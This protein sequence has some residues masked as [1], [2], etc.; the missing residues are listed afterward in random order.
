MDKFQK[1]VNK[2]NV[3]T[4]KD[5]IKIWD[6]CESNKNTNNIDTGKK[7]TNV[8]ITDDDRSHMLEHCDNESMALMKRFSEHYLL[9]HGSKKDVALPKS[10][11]EALKQLETEDPVKQKT[12]NS[13]TPRATTAS[14]VSD[15]KT[16]STT[17]TTTKSSVVLDDSNMIA[18]YL[19]G[20]ALAA[21]YILRAN[22]T[23]L[24]PLQRESKD[25]QD[26]T[27]DITLNKTI[28]DRASKAGRVNKNE[29]EYEAE[30]DDNEN[31]NENAKEEESDDNASA[32]NK[33][34]SEEEGDDN[35]SDKDDNEE[36]G[37]NSAS[38]MDTEKKATEETVVLDSIFP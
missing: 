28:S 22:N 1:R 31:K 19:D 16:R 11:Q 29:K 34:N 14:D 8:I 36:E 12:H 17:T 38:K 35:A 33:N 4:L 25:L 10:Y 32:E 5:I 7:C 26:Y 9:K 21:E 30:M 27:N 13:Y 18:N 3:D 15:Y 6:I 37:D 23:K 20:P 2:V 24:T